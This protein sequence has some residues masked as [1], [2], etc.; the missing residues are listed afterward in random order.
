M[1][2]Q[3]GRQKMNFTELLIEHSSDPYKFKKYLTIL[4][5]AVD[6]EQV[7]LTKSTC[8]FDDVGGVGTDKPWFY[9]ILLFEIY[10]TESRCVFELFAD[11]YHGN[12]QF[13]KVTRTE[14]N[15]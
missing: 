1:M 6:N 14:D 7:I 15:K 9:D 4:K 2:R 11:T 10:D 5:N 8:S 13:L 12:W 3:N